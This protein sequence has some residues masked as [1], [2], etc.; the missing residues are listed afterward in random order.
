VTNS[1]TARRLFSVPLF[2]GHEWATLTAQ[3]LPGRSGLALGLTAARRRALLPAV[4]PRLEQEDEVAIVLPNLS[5]RL[6]DGLEIADLVF[7]LAVVGGHD[8]AC[9]HGSDIRDVQY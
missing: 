4:A 9:H 7:G 1:G 2:V 6:E 5:E 8:S 3:R